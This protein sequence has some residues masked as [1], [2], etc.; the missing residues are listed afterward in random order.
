[1]TEER[2]EYT[3]SVELQER[4]DALWASYGVLATQVRDYW[5]AILEAAETIKELKA[6]V[7]RL[8]QDNRRLR[9]LDAMPVDVLRRYVDKTDRVKNETYS[10]Q[11][12]YEDFLED[13]EAIDIWLATLDGDA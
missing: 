11:Y 9:H 5:D 1:M 4:L 2:T 8:E 10:R 6:T 13:R 12:L 7:Q 3:V